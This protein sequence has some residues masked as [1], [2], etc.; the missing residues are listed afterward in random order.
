MMRSSAKAVRLEMITYKAR[1]L[2]FGLRYDIL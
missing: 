2:G 1:T